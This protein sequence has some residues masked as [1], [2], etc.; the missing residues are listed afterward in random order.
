MPRPPRFI[1]GV[2]AAWC[3]SHRTSLSL[4]GLVGRLVETGRPV[5]WLDSAKRH[6]ATGRYSIVGWDPWLTLSATGSVI[7]VTS[8]ASR[9]ELR[10]NPLHLL[11]QT[12]RRYPGPRNRLLPPVG[13]GL[14]TFLGYELN[15]W[16]ERLPAAKPVDPITPQLLAYGMR[17]M[18]IVDHETDLSWCLSVI[19][20]YQPEARGTAEA[21]Q[22]LDEAED[23]MWSLPASQPAPTLDEGLAPATIQP[24]VSQAQFEQMVVR[25]KDEIARGEIFQANLSQQFSGPWSG[26]PWALYR[27]LRQINPS[28]FACFASLPEATIVSC[29][30]ERLVRV[31][32]DTVS[33]RPIAGTRP[34]GA[35]PE[36]DLVQSLELMLSEK[37]R[38]EHIMLVDLA[39]NDLGR[40]CSAGSVAV[41]ELFAV[42]DYS[43]V[44]H[45]VSNVRGE[46]KDG[47]DAIDVIQAVFPGGTITGCPKVRSMQIIR[48]LE[49]VGRGFYT[50]S[51]GHIGFDGSLDLNILIRTFVLQG[52]RLSFHVGAGIVA[53]SDPQREYQETLAKGAALMKA[54]RLT[55]VPAPRPVAGGPAR[56]ARRAEG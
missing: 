16:I 53:D 6:K 22:R 41:D 39:R 25:A 3:Q 46:L 42:E 34:R 5:I 37:E 21:R 26:S 14:L 27:A 8:R 51:A 32:Q 18:V 2:P 1:P 55:A 47:I 29:S 54:L 49:P 35:R 43:H 24:M 36:D 9:L 40:I 15:Q 7:T 20:P 23:L 48:D 11:R 52:D 19:D 50:G 31:H 45:L 13:H 4:E 28:P 12:L 56:A 17:L 33:V 10:G 30:P 44:M 38:A